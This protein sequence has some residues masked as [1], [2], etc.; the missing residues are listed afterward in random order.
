MDDNGKNRNK[1]SQ[2]KLIVFKGKEIR[3]AWR[4]N[5]WFYSLVDVVGVLTESVNPTDYLKKIRKRDEMLGIY[6]G[7]NCPH[8]E[9]KTTT[10]KNRKTIA[11]N[12]KDIFRLI[13]SIPSKRAE[14][15]TFV[16]G[17]G[18]QRSA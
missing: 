6:V 7:T 10:G 18:W 8:V 17:A 13:Q 2:N 15:F 9:M 12:T 4:D 14:P 3:R 5:E 1:E 16:A 11:G